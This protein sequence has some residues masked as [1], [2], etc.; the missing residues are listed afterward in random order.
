MTSRVDCRPGGGRWIA[1]GGWRIP[2]FGQVDHESGVLYVHASPDGCKGIVQCGAEP[3]AR[4]SVLDVKLALLV[5]AMNLSAHSWMRSARSVFSTS[6]RLLRCRDRPRGER[7]AAAST[8]SRGSRPCSRNWS[9]CCTIST[10]SA[11]AAERLVALQFSH[12]PLPIGRSCPGCGATRQTFDEQGGAGSTLPR[13]RA[14]HRQER[15]KGVSAGDEEAAEAIRDLVETVTV[16]RDDTRP[17]GVCVE[18]AGRLNSLIGG[19]ACLSRVRG[20]G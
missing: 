19:E 9:S 6:P 8:C 12:D 5:V 15:R 16:S 14:E 7:T 10:P 18:I 4:S 2:D 11:V 13:F 3:F 1:A 17:G 20:V